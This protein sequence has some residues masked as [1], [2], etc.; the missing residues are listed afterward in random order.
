MSASDQA[1]STQASWGAIALANLQ[2]WFPENRR[3]FISIA[4]LYASIYALSGALETTPYNA[5]VYLAQAFLEGHFHVDNLPEFMEET[6]LNGHKYIAYGITPALVMMPFVAIW[7][8]AFHQSLYFAL[9][10]GVAVAVWHS[11]LGKLELQPAWRHMLTTVMG[12]GSLF[13]FYA[14]D[15]GR[16]WW[17][18]HVATVLFL[19]IAIRDCVGKQRAWVA[20]LAFGLAV[21]SRQSVFLGLPFFVGMLWRDDRSQGGL[22]VAGKAWRFALPLAALLAFNCFYNYAR[23]GAPLDNGYAR[24]ISETDTLAHGFF[25]TH[26]LQENLRL[27]LFGVPQRLERF[28]WFD[29]TMGGFSIFISTPALLLA[30][31][32][33]WRARINQLALLAVLGIGTFYMFYYWSGFTQFGCRYSLDFLPF[34][35]LLVASAVRDRWLEALRTCLLAGITVQVWG[36]FW[37]MHK[38]W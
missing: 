8:L 4:V 38:G 29:T 34:A 5:H 13:W 33:D 9:L 16:T 12:L 6:H 21:L 20:G 25:S 30:F 32:A 28:P 17:I 2:G 37:W 35:L 26:Y 18:M 24:V 36:L 31:F 15:G 11:V 10:G 1:R 19:L 27:Y 14:G 7:G 22:G 23:F 3:E